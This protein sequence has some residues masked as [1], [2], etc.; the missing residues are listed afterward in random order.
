MAVLEA[1]AIASCV[2]ARLVLEF[3]FVILFST[4]K[5]KNCSDECGLNAHTSL[6]S[7]MHLTHFGSCVRLILGRAFPAFWVMLLV[8]NAP[9]HTRNKTPKNKV[10][11]KGL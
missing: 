2:L 1:P 6:F 11:L 4:T 3:F 10:D 7:K 9:R 8:C 5:E